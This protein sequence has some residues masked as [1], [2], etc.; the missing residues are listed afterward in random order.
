MTWSD[1]ELVSR[2]IGGDV[3]SFNQLVLRG[4]RPIYALAYR[5]IGREEDA[6]DVCQ[7]TF[8]RAFRA[9]GGFRGQAKFSSWL[10]RIA[11]NL[12]RDWVR[13]QKPPPVMQMP[14]GVDPTELASERG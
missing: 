12:C 1:E 11:L 14:E 13:R 10:Y 8:L 5:V 9:L 3:D 6:R 7:E 4:E 2:S